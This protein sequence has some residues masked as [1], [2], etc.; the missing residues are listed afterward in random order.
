MD[1]EKILKMNKEELDTYKWHSDLSKKS[2]NLN[3]SDCSR[4]SRCSD[5]SRCSGCS[6]CSRCY[7]CSG[8]S[9]CSRCSS[10]SDCYDCRNA[11]GM[12]YAICNIEVGE[13]AYNLKMKELEA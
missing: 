11:V 13:S 10:C 2:T 5:C 7:G 12:K 9:G 4:C 1:K 3:C 8:C 6:D